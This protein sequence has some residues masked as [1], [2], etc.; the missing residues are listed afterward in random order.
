[1]KQNN[2]GPRY[3]RQE[4]TMNVPTAE[5]NATKMQAFRNYLDGQGKTREDL[6]EDLEQAKERARIIYE[7]NRRQDYEAGVITGLDIAID[8]V[9]RGIPREPMAR[10][11]T[12]PLRGPSM[13][14]QLIQRQNINE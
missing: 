11:N 5:E 2:L 4:D 13:G 14:L 7:Q 8:L 12:N 1:V 10:N 3:V 9:R 6:I